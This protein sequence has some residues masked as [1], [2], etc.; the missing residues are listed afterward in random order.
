MRKPIPSST[1]SRTTVK[2]ERVYVDFFV[3]SQFSPL[4][5]SALYIYIYLVGL[6]MTRMTWP[7]FLRVKSDATDSFKSTSPTLELTVLPRLSSV[8]EAMGVEIFISAILSGHAVPR[9]RGLRQELT[10]A[11]IPERNPQ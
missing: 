4:A 10:T 2:L 9:E 8:F 11:N 1:N 5:G 7:Y 6:D 3:R